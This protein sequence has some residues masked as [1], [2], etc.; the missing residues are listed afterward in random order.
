LI[1]LCVSHQHA[2]PSHPRALLRARRERPRGYRA[3]EQRDE[4]APFQLIEL[5]SMPASQAGLQDD[6]IGRGQPG[7]IGTILQPASRCE[8]SLMAESDPTRP[9][10]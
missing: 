8:F 6:Q 10:R 4:L 7:G 5:H 3:A 1:A 2:D 9:W